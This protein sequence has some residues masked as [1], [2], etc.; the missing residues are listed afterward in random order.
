MSA[1]KYREK[2]DKIIVESSGEIVF[3]GSHDHAAVVIERMFARARESVKILTRKF[4]PRIYCDNSTVNSARKM[5]GDSSRRI[6]ILVEDIDATVRTDNPYFQKLWKAGNL[7]IR[8]V[9]SHLKGPLAINF[10]LMDNSGFRLEKDQTG[11]TAIVC[12][13][14]ETI[15]S[16]LNSLFVEVWAKSERIVG[17]EERERLLA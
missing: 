2:I 3:N 12:F 17:P 16:R 8:E 9:P 11:A 1:I 13:G 14:D 6:E 10:A 7:Q 5:L 4:D 15:A